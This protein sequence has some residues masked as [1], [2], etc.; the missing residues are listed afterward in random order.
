MS[1]DSRLPAEW[2][3]THLVTPGDNLLAALVG[4]NNGA[5][6]KMPLV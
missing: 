5:T 4:D 1:K 3:V 2:E 6:A